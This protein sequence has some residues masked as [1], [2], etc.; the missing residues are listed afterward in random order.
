[1]V[2]V[3]GFGYAWAGEPA[4][5]PT[6]PV[7]VPT[8]AI[9]AA[10]A[11]PAGSAPRATLLPTDCAELLP[12]QPDMS[13]LLGRPT[14]SVGMHT[15]VGVPAPSVGQRERLTCVYLNGG[16]TLTLGAFTDPASATAQ[17]DRNI[18]VERTDS[19]AIAPAALGLARA[20]MLT[21]SSR[22]LLLVAYDRYTL[23]AAMAPGVVP[24]DQAGPVLT[25]LAQRVLP[26]L[27]PAQR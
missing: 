20:T 3:A 12:G 8:F 7:A 6:A 13:A 25:D 22:R 5:V 24:D 18:A 26:R 4:P 21:E 9:P 17:R 11:G 15:V 27:A 16:L 2:L 10:G 14:G 19:L 1:M 23:T